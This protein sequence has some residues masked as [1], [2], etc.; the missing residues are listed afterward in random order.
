MLK[1]QNRVGILL[2][3]KIFI[4]KNLIFLMLTFLTISTSTFS[5]ESGNLNIGELHNE[6]L[7][8]VINGDYWSQIETNNDYALL[9]SELVKSLHEQLSDLYSLSEIQN[10]LNQSISTQEEMNL[11]F[12]DFNFTE[13]KKITSYLIHNEKISRPLGKEINAIFK[14]IFLETSSMESLL[15]RVTNLKSMTLSQ[16]DKI[17]A[18]AFSD[19]FVSSYELW[20]GEEDNDI[21]MGFDWDDLMLVAC[22]AAGGIIGTALTGGLGGV[23]AG[24]AASGAYVVTHYDHTK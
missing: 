11:S 6:I 16:G 23:V 22:D 17:Y 15:T 7:K 9:N 1:S 5:Q 8:E 19:V 12:R 4:M 20:G 10:A 3:Q 13:S 18:D 14:T 24:A 21:V 2:L